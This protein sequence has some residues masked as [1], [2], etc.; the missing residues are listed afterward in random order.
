MG[1]E[2][3]QE[4]V[5]LVGRDPQFADTFAPSLQ[6]CAN[7]KVFTQLQALDYI[8]SRIRVARRMW[9]SRKPKAR[10]RLGRARAAGAC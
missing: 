7:E 10:D 9:P 6:E 3:D 5:Q 4:I 8:G 2:S 1:V